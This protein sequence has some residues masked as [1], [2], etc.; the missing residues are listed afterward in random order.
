MV[1]GSS[2]YLKIISIYVEDNGKV[3]KSSQFIIN[4][5]TSNS[6]AQIEWCLSKT[7]L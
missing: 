3:N 1:V 4:G 5:E 2:S 7:H 6:G